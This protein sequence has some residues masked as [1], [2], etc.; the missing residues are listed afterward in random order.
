MANALIACS[1]I[2]YA[3][4]AMRLL[5]NAGIRASIR[6]LPIGSTDTGCSQAV[7]VDQSK[8][9]RSVALMKNAGFTARY[10]FC[11]KENGEVAPCP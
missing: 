11:E 6:R 9:D 3:Q 7:R 2:T 4:R 5:N 8:L 10:T 1:S